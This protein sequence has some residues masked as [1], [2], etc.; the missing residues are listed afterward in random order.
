MKLKIGLQLY[1]VRDDMAA[2]FEGTLKAVAEMGYEGVEF[3]GLYGH[4]IA[5]VKALCKKYGLVPVSAHV[6]LAEMLEDLPGTLKA[7]KDL[8]CEYIV[9]PYLPEEYRPQAGNFEETLKILEY[10]GREAAAAGLTL[11]YHNHD[12]EFTVIDGEY[13]LDTIYRRVSAEYLQTEIDTCWANV[14]GADPSEYVR[15]Y[16]GRAPV[17]H[18]KDFYKKG[19][20]NEG[21]YELIGIEKKASASEESFGFRP[22][23]F[24]MQN[25]PEIIKASEDAGARWLVVEQ[26][27][28]SPEHTAMED[29]RRSIDYL[30]SL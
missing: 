19:H 3:A 17:V 30:K 27:R 25:M 2:D 14:G 26:D 10:V 6:S 22:V 15:K 9:V 28:P 16:T 12:F 4:S 7:Y 23:G 8:G 1:S 5:E 18:L 21:L 29:V 20:K 11:L 24:G 13:Y